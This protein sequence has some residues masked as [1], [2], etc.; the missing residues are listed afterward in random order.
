MCTLQAERAD[1]NRELIRYSR[2]AGVSMVEAVRCY[3][4]A[5]QLVREEPA[6]RRKERVHA[7]LAVCG[8]YRVPIGEARV[9]QECDRYLEEIHRS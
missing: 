4:D 7:A 2:R 8:K 6:P 9:A 1:R 3:V 5:Q